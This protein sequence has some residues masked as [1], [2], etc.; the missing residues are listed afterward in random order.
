MGYVYQCNLKIKFQLR[1][2]LAIKCYANIF[3]NNHHF[4]IAIVK[5][6][7]LT[8]VCDLPALY[9]SMKTIKHLPMKN[10]CF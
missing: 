7:G 9:I 2:R 6:Y 5:N 10:F 8:F 4:K 3:F 1:N